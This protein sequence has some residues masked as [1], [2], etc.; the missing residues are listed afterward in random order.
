MAQNQAKLCNQAY[1]SEIVKCDML[2]K[3]KS[4]QVSA[5]MQLAKLYQDMGNEEKALE[6]MK[7]VEEILA[8]IKDTE[9]ELYNL[10]SDSA[11]NSDEVHEY[12]KRGRMAMGIDGES[13]NTHKSP[14]N[15]AANK[16][17][18]SKNKEASNKTQKSKD[19]EESH[20]K[21]ESKYKAT[22]SLMSFESVV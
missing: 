3:S 19:N 1:D 13:N 4:G 17:Q 5:I 14:D 7:E 15:E 9:A 18:K 11:A 12:L 22:S 16:K 20:E 21:Q 8:Q 10:E 6:K 2:I